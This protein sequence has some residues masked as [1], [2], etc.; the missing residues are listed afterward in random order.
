[1]TQCLSNSYCLSIS[2]RIKIV[3]IQISNRCVRAQWEPP[4]KLGQNTPARIATIRLSTML[5]W[6]GLMGVRTRRCRVS[7]VQWTVR[8]SFPPPSHPSVLQ[9]N[10]QPK[11]NR[12]NKSTPTHTNAFTA[13][14][15]TGI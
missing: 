9:V 6:E 5:N 7:N 14:P 11:A 1:M 8:R 12:G 3:I 15:S 13:S 2:L 10:R 4:L